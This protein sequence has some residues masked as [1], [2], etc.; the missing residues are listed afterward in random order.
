MYHWTHHFPIINID[1]DKYFS[2]YKLKNTGRKGKFGYA[3]NIKF[4]IRGG[5]GIFLLLSW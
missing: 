1:P 4:V 5:G 2:G 3:E